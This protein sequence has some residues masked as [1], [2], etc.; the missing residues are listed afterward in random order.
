VGREA[1]SFWR[2]K[3]LSSSW[4][5][6]GGGLLLDPSFVVDSDRWVVS[7]VGRLV[8]G[9]DDSSDEEDVRGAT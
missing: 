9:G 6:L 2:R 1:S 3:F 5:L 4:L 8:V 7:M